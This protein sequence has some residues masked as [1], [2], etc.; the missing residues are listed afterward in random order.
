MPE[1]GG[2]EVFSAIKCITPDA[3]IIVYTGFHQ[4]EHSLYIEIADKFLLKSDDPEK[5][6]QAIAELS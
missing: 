4:Y 2:I 1:K 6:L 5:L 3:K